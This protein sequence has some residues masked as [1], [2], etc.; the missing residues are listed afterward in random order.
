MHTR[1]IPRAAA[2]ARGHGSTAPVPRVPCPFRSTFFGQFD[3]P[4][5]HGRHG[6]LTASARSRHLPEVMTE[7]E[8][9]QLREEN[10]VFEIRIRKDIRVLKARGYIFLAKMCVHF[11]GDNIARWRYEGGYLRRR[12]VLLTCSETQSNAMRLPRLALLGKRGICANL[13][14][15]TLPKSP[16]QFDEVSDVRLDHIH[17][18]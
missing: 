18:I 12:R 3:G 14:K 13:D 17:A 2:R 7:V 6:R 15:P 9:A 1:K 5:K 8:F 4:L 11:G 16:P 10:N